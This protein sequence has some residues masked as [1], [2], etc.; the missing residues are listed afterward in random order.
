MTQPII[1]QLTTSDG[2]RIH[3]RH[4]PA[5]A[6]SGECQGIVI[7]LHGIQSHSGWYEYSSRRMAE[8][9]FDV[10]FA[11]RRG[12][13]LNGFQ[14]GHAVHAM[15]LI[16]DVRALRQLAVNEHS[17]ANHEGSSLPV[18]LMGISWGGKIAAAACALFPQEF[19]RLALLYPGLEPRLRLTLWQ[20]LRLNLARD[21]EVVKRHIAIP[22]DDPSLFTQS[23]EWQSFIANDALALHTVSS[24][25]LN[26]G[27]ALDAIVAEHG[28][29][30]QQST[31][32]MLAEQDEII[33]NDRVRKRVNSFGCQNLR[34]LIYP[35]ARHTLEFEPNREAIFTDLVSW[36]TGHQ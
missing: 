24:S 12:S 32:L 29:Q 18:V 31:L 8:A 21:F 35:A 5:Q 6:G 10:Y 34:T 17:T 19:A 28:R 11:D 36:L 26:A 7:G 1:R 30:I 27:R 23:A 16:H 33:D 20:K 13:G 22:L 25:F 2:Y 14:R 4:W 9:G 3:F 15:R